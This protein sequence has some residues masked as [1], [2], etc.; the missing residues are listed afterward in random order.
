MKKIFLVVFDYGLSQSIPI[1]TLLPMLEVTCS[2]NESYS[3]A[4]AEETVQNPYGHDPIL[5]IL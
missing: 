1:H 4:L 2:H 5:T 3:E